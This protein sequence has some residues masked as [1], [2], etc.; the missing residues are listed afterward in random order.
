MTIDPLIEAVRS[1]LIHFCRVPDETKNTF[2]SRSFSRSKD[3]ELLKA[4]SD[5]VA[6]I[7]LTNI[8]SCSICDKKAK[9]NPI[10]HFYSL[11]LKKKKAFKEFEPQSTVN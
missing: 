7:R 4:G 5:S 1:K 6:T 9:Y 11:K 8:C 3:S 2:E 10:I